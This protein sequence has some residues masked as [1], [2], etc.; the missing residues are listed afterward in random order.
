[1]WRDT[2]AG[3]RCLALSATGLRTIRINGARSGRGQAASEIRLGLKTKLKVSLITIKPALRGLQAAGVIISVAGKGAYV[4]KQA[5]ILR[6]LD[7]TVPSFEGTTMKVRSI[8]RERTSDPVVLTFRSPREAMLCVR[9]TI[10]TDDMPFL[11]D[12]TYLSADVDGEIVD[13]FAERLVT[14]TLLSSRA[15]TTS[16]RRV[17]ADSRNRFIVLYKG[18]S[19]AMRVFAVC[20]KR[21]SEMNPRSDNRTADPCIGSWKRATAAASGASLTISCLD[22]L[23]AIPDKSLPV[24]RQHAQDYVTRS[25]GWEC[26][27]LGPGVSG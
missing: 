17:D 7:L 15:G 25:A 2:R 21:K 3:W 11:Y 4:K 23:F 19:S 12:S 9:K 16:V 24:P 18:G 1:M 20:F 8:T 26:R 22:H 5:R 13:E 6:A 10:V 27:G 14:E